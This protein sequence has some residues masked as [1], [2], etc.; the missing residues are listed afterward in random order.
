MDVVKTFVVIHNYLAYTDEANTPESRYI[1][2]TFTDTDSAG[3]VEPGE[4]RRVVAGES[5]LESVNAP[6]MSRSRST[7][8]AVGV[9]NELMQFFDTRGSVTLAERHSVAWHTSPQ[10]TRQR[11]DHLII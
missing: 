11:H 6:H 1:P 3:S 10:M 7:R 5:N 4:W 8:A 9:R 2:P